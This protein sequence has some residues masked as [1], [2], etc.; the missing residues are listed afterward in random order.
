VKRRSAPRAAE[1]APWERPGYT[2][3]IGWP[4]GYVGTIRGEA[5]DR[6]AIARRN[7]ER[8][9]ALGDTGTIVGLSRKGAKEGAPARAK[10]SRCRARE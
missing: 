5:V 3:S 1:P 2:F 9:V 4:A 6:S 10:L 7:R 8:R